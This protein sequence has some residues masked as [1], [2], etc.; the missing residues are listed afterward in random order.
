M[1]GSSALP[2]VLGMTTAPED[3]EALILRH[4]DSPSPYLGIDWALL[5]M[6]D[7]R[8]CQSLRDDLEKV[9]DAW[10]VRTA[11]ASTSDMIPD[12]PGLYMFVWRPW[13][14][15]K[16]AESS[17]PGDLAEIL[18]VGL[19][20][21]GK[22]AQA[23][24]KSRYHTGYRKYF[25]GNPAALWNQ[26]EPTQR[27]G[28]LERYLSVTPLEYWF[29][30]VKDRDQISLLEDRLIQLLNPPINRSRI[31]KVVRGTTQPAF[32]RTNK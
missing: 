2:G 17:R 30:V 3:L 5:R 31:P 12:E 32:T 19:A 1:S 10:E 15:F 8:G 28:R 24:L 25:P 29:L 20:G 27:H 9:S 11:T 14:R 26:T 21:A 6:L 13:F 16:V 22:Y 18:Y 7:R 23:T 4:R